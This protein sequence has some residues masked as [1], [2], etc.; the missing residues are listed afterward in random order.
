MSGMERL[1]S[2]LQILHSNLTNTSRITNV[3]KY[4]LVLSQENRYV[5]HGVG[6]LKWLGVITGGGQ[7]LT[8]TCVHSNKVYPV[9]RMQY[10]LQNDMPTTA[11]QDIQISCI[12]SYTCIDNL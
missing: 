5:L 3:E 8:D 11:P 1:Y 2:E 12:F 7:G 10:H 9:Q 6:S 4:V